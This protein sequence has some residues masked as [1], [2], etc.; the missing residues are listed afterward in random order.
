MLRKMF[1]LFLIAASMCQI[2]ADVELSTSINDVYYRGSSELA[3]SI[4]LYVT[5]NDFKDTSPE[6][7]KFIRITLD[8]NAKLSSTLVDQQAQGAV[9]NPVYLA[10]ELITEEGASLN[11]PADTASIVRWVEGE[12]S[13]WL[14]IQQDSMTWVDRGGQ[15]GPP[16]SDSM[17]SFTAGVSARTSVTLFNDVD[18]AHK[19]LPFNTRNLNATDTADSISTLICM[20]LSD[21]SVTTSG[22]DSLI[23][24]DI[25]AFDHTAEQSPGVYGPG[26]L[27]RINFASDFRIARAKDRS[28][29]VPVFGATGANTCLAD[30]I[31]DAQNFTTLSSNLNFQLNSGSGGPYLTTDLYPG[32]Y[33][34]LS[35]PAGAEYGFESPAVRFCGQ[36]MTPG[37]EYLDNPTTINGRTI[38]RTATLVWTGNVTAISNLDL[39]VETTLQYYLGANP[40]D[41]SLEWQFTFLNHGSAYDDAPYD[42]EE[43]KRRCDPSEFSPVQGSTLIG[44][45]SNQL[46]VTRQ[47]EDLAVCAGQPASFEVTGSGGGISYQWYKDDVPLNLE[48]GAQLSLGPVDVDDSGSYHCE[49]TNSCGTVVTRRAL[50][51]INEGEPCSETPG[52]G[53]RMVT[54]ITGFGNGFDTSIVFTNKGGSQELVSYKI[55]YHSSP[56]Q[57]FSTQ[58]AAL[59]EVT[60]S[61]RDEASSGASHLELTDASDNVKMT[62][63]YRSTQDNAGPA[64]ARETTEV[65]RRWHLF[66]GNPQVTWDGVAIVNKGSQ[67]AEVTLLQVDASGQELGRM[68]IADSLSVD[69]KT[70]ALLADLFTYQEGAS[71][72]VTSSQPLAI[73]ALRGN[74]NSTFLWESPALALEE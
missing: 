22:I 27:T 39:E 55:Y 45:I 37:T 2:Q 72:E 15:L 30:I 14:R 63:V 66:G 19:N 69:S 42:G 74:L 71:F 9:G 67:S 41:A 34:T 23:S 60:H 35:V 43:Q 44:S 73:I 46:A 26:N 17:V 4:T 51:T 61:L 62:V 12:T 21:S 5:E 64:H 36:G 18:D 59:S 10:M 1:L 48:T 8:K 33:I 29:E 13:I 25:V 40:G 16:S 6:E 7:P 11:A 53:L 28:V 56:A 47:P 70:I 54:H 20:D 57:T 65:S 50:L 38:Y 3:G 52:D 32:A 31:P 49:L 68:A 24:Y 58:V